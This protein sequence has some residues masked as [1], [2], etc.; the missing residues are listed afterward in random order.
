VLASYFLNLKLLTLNAIC[1]FLF[2]IQFKFISLYLITGLSNLFHNGGE[3]FKTNP[4]KSNEDQKL[5]N[6]KEIYETL[7]RH[8]NELSYSYGKYDWNDIRSPEGQ[9]Y[10]KLLI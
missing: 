2:V 8:I 7:K 4:S 5:L 1:L 3:M 6:E 9:Q 10:I